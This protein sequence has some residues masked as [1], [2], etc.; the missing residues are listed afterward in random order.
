[1]LKPDTHDYAHYGIAAVLAGAVGYG[2]IALH[3]APPAKAPIELT[4]FAAALSKIPNKAE[5]VIYCSPCDERA[6]AIADAFDN[7]GWKSK[8]EP[9][10]QAKPG[11]LITGFLNDLNSWTGANTFSEVIGKVTSQSG[12]TYTF[13]SADCGTEVTF[14]NGATVTTTIPASLPTGCNIAVAQIGSGLI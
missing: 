2:G 1:M 10:I 5:V 11:V 8:M 14:S 6:T 4:H 9:A 13:A 12:T 3:N 7:A